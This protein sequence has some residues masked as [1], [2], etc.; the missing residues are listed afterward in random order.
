[1]LRGGVTEVEPFLMG[2]EKR[3]LN[4]KEKVMN[5]VCPK[6]YSDRF[7]IQ[8]AAH[9]RFDLGG[10]IARSAS[11]YVFLGHP[12]EQIIGSPLLL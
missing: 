12:A 7:N 9:L 10:Y 8:S 6:L 5:F 2:I 3:K 11:E 1:M 4:Y